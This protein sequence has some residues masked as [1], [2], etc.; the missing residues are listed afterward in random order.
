MVLLLLFAVCQMVN[1][2]CSASRVGERASKDPQNVL[3]SM[4]GIGYKTVLAGFDW[5]CALCGLYC[6]RDISL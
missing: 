2:N 6:Q 1:L 4:F 3:L 5:R